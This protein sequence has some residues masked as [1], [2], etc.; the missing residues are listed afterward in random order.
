MSD[1]ADIQAM[2]ESTGQ[3]AHV[4]AK[5][6]IITEMVLE[7]FKSYAGVQRVGPFHKVRVGP[8][9]QNKMPSLTVRLCIQQHNRGP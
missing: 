8:F 2:D 1:K 7:N 4:S 5:R 6:L 9:Q 3:D